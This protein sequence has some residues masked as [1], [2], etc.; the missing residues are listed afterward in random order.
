M[1]SDKKRQSTIDKKIKLYK[2]NDD[3][4]HRKME[5]IEQ[6]FKIKNRQA[7]EKAQKYRQ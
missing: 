1:D 5:S 4:W 3:K 7:I 6:K 2:L